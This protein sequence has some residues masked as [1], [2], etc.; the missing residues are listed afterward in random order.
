[1]RNLICFP[2]P[3]LFCVIHNLHFCLFCSN[4]LI[5]WFQTL[6]VNRFENLPV[7]CITTSKNDPSDPKMKLLQWRFVW[8]QFQNAVAEPARVYWE[9]QHAVLF[10]SLC[11]STAVRGRKLK[12]KKDKKKKK[13]KHQLKCKLI[14]TTQ[15]WLLSTH[16]SESLGFKVR[17]Q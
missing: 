12:R 2:L 5:M 10:L 14:I 15:A 13:L 6:W 1:M 3:L 8:D 11:V 17:G 16:S 9:Q 7:N 4:I